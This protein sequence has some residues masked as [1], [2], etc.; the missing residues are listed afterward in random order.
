MPRFP[1]VPAAFLLAAA[2][3]GVPHAQTPIVAVSPG[4]FEYHSAFWVNLHHLLYEQARALE[5]LDSGRV[6]VGQALRDTAGIEGLTAGERMAWDLALRYYRRHLARHD[7]LERDMAAIKAALGDRENAPALD[8]LLV[9]ANS[10]ADD[11]LRM[12]LDAA[13][14]AYRR[15]WWSRHDQGNRAWIAGMRARVDR[16][17]PALARE[18]ARIFHIP[19]SDFLIRVDASAYANWSG[20]YTTNYPDRITVATTDSDYAGSSGLEMLFHESLHTLDDSVRTALARAAKAHGTRVPPDLVHAMIFFTAGE[21]TRRELSAESPHYLPT[22]ER[23]GIWQ[24]GGF[25]RHLPLL[26]RLWLPWIEGRSSFTAAI[27][28]IAGALSTIE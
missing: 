3:S 23:L 13:A 15:A 25:P 7:V 17:G 2:C 27:D 9:R 4:L 5:G 18:L 6:I 16:H 1:A 19:W 14:P 20:A 21:V 10:F 24:R 12:V 28:S 26:R 8:R 22:A 11:S